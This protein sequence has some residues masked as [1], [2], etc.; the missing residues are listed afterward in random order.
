MNPQRIDQ[1]LAL[2]RD[3]LLKDSVPFWLNHN[4]G[5]ECGGFYNYLDRDGSLYS[6]DKPVWIQG[7]FTWLMATL[8]NTVE[9][10]PEW[11]DSAVAPPGATR[12]VARTFRS[13]CRAT[14]GSICPSAVVCRPA[15]A[16][17]SVGASGSSELPRQ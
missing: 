17:A 5:E 14:S 10:R 6:T 4:R 8:Y 16:K 7:R 9:K 3:D 1:L 13:I 11:L 15:F 2:H 12:S